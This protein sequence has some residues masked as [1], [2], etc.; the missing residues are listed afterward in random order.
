MTDNSSSLHCIQNNWIVLVDDWGGFMARL[1]TNNETL[2]SEVINKFLPNTAA[3]DILVGYFYFS[4]LEEIYKNLDDVKV[5]ILVGMNIERAF[6][7][8]VKEFVYIDENS[9]SISRLQ[10]RNDYFESL[11]DLFNNS[12]YFDTKERQDAFRLFLNK[13]DDGSLE[14][15]KTADPNHAKLYLFGYK[16]SHTNQGLTPGVMVTGS[17][18]LTLS[19]LSNRQELNVLLLNKYADGKAI[20]DKLWDEA[21]DLVTSDHKDNFYTEVFEK[22]WLDK[23]P[24]PYLLY[25]RLLLEYF[26]VEEEG[27][28]VYPNTITKG[29]FLDLKYQ[30]DAISKGI[31]IINQHNGVLIADVVGLGKSIIASAIAYNLKKRVIIIASPGLHYQWDQVYSPLFHLNSRTFGPRSIHKAIEYHQNTLLGE[32]VVIIVDEAHNFRNEKSENYLPLHQLCQGNKVILL[33]ATP[34]NNKPQ[35]LFALIKLFQIP[36]RSTMSSVRNLSHTVSEIKS[37][38]DEI[39]RDYRQASSKTGTS[40]ID[41]IKMDRLGKELRSVLE[42]IIIRRSRLDIDIIEAYKKDL[43]KQKVKYLLAEPPVEKVYQLGDLAGLYLKTLQRITPLSKEQKD[44]EEEQRSENIEVPAKLYGARYKPVEY[45]INPPEFTKYLESQGLDINLQAFRLGQFNLANLMMRFLA[46]RFESS[47]DSFKKTLDQ[48]IK[49]MHIIRNYYIERDVVPIMKKGTI[50][51]YTDIDEKDI[52]S[53]ESLM[54]ELDEAATLTDSEEP[55]SIPKG[56]FFIPKDYL[57]DKFIRPQFRYRFA[58]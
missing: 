50:P 14:I 48:L 22:I 36:Y 19:G 57:N 55:S 21:I 28:I 7:N 1:I 5:K 54:E 31:S 8:R 27:D 46:S 37:K 42:P 52:P 11:V 25:V 34:F 16:P 32:E 6:S 24:S 53:G 44:K 49:S 45:L 58:Y 20:F 35:D 10:I 13:I 9:Q 41:S 12:N 26:E 18:N 33:T 2:L 40:T 38:Y 17:S 39:Y 23:L 43:E 3:L 56:L 30:K 47:I 51:I 29:R 4:G 15:K